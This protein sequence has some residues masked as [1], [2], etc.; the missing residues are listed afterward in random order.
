MNHKE[1]TL[2]CEG[3]KECKEAVSYIDE[4]GFIYC[5]ICGINRQMTMR[6]RKLT[7]TE[8]NTLKKGSPIKKY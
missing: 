6:C 5:P 4:K 7:P 8:L 1:K 2:T 3:R